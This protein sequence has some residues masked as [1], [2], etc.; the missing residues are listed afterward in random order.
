M[1]S[2]EQLKK[3]HINPEWLDGLNATFERFDIATP[4]RM[5]AFIGQC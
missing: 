3:L 1:I 5:A 2:A 4:L